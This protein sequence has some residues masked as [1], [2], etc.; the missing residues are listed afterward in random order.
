VTRQEEIRDEAEALDLEIAVHRVF[1][2]ISHRARQY[3]W[4]NDYA[5][6]IKAATRRLESLLHEAQQLEGT[7]D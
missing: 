4:V 5:R 1:L 2:E 6:K 7:C 3:E